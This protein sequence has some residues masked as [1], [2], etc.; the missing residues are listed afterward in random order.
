MI[1]PSYG[2]RF[3]YS[4]ELC[5]DIARASRASWNGVQPALP[6]P[7][8]GMSV[9]RVD[10]MVRFYGADVMLLIGGSLLTAGDALLERTRA[11]VATV[12][13]NSA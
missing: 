10:E 5:A 3:A 4:R 8:G 2:G 7:A 11:F 6:V 9:E 12:E 1:Y 13:R